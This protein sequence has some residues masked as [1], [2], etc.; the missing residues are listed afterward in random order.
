[1]NS[2]ISPETAYDVIVRKDLSFD[3]RL[4]VAV[5][6][7]GIFCRPGCPARLPK[8]ENCDFFDTAQAALT[9]GFRA[10]KRCHPAKAPGAE[11]PLIARLIALVEDSPDTRLTENVLKTNGIDPS[12]ARRQFQARF[13]MS[14]TQYARARRLARAAQDIGK[15][16]SVISAQITAG[17]ES[18][19]GFRNAFGKTFGGPPKDAAVAPLLIDWF[20]SPHGTMLAVAD[21]DALYMLEFTVR[22]NLDLQMRRL[23]KKTG[24]AIL[25]GRTG[26]TDQIKAELAAYF[27]GDLTG[28]ETPVALL[29]TAF[30]TRTWEALR[31]IPCGQTRSYK[32]L[33]DAVGNPKGFRAVANANANNRLAIIVPC[34]RVIASDGGLG[35]YA[36]GLDKKRA[37]LDLEIKA[38]EKP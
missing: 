31:A 21:E 11:R 29:G 26:I 25:P 37:L 9:A 1:M 7:T 35:G 18:A 6:T 36:G 17:Y 19:S 33:A 13:N 27:A 10:C 20:D 22:K 30:Q 24:R 4:F 38:A 32:D 28:F 16:D 8:F 5:K 15:G 12:T 3:G 14:F 23:A 34:H 2:D